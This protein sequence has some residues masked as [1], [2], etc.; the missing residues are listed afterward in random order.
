[1]ATGKPKFYW[2]AAPLIA[3]IT[4]EKRADPSEMDGLAEVVEMVE[5]GSA[6]LLTSV[7]WRAEVLELNLSKAQRQKLEQSFDGRSFIELSVDGR[8]L[9]L[10]GEIRTLQRSSKKKDA[11]KNIRTPDAI[12]LATAIQYDATEFHTF[13]G[14]RSGPNRGG[15]LSLDGNVGGHRLRICVPHAT[16]L[17]LNFP[18]SPDNPEAE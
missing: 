17:R 12:H 9:D 13:D 15:L 7:L 8:I 3:W 1:M 18:T 16:Q 10:A 4:N 11:I 14:K 6:V 2:D 5:R